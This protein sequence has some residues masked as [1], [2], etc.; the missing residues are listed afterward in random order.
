MGERSA[1]PDLVLE[2]ETGSTLMTP[3]H[4]YHVGR[5]PLSDI[6]IEDARVSWHH[7]VLR[8]GTDHWTL[9][10]ENSTNGTYADGRRVHE[11]DVGAGSVIHFG[12]PS[13]GPRAVLADRP[14]PAPERPSVVSAPAATGTFRR[15]TSVRPLPS[16]TVRIGRSGD[17]DL[18]VDD[19]GVSRR[20]AELR[21]LPDGTYEIVDL[22]S[23][24]G[25]FLNGQPVTRSRVGAGDIVGI[26]H[27]AFCLVGDQ[28]QEYVDTGEVS[29]DVQDLSVAVDR[30]RKTLLDRVSFPVG[31]KCLL[32]VVGPSGAGKSTLLNALTGQRPADRG[33]VLYDGRDLYRDYAELRRR[34]GLVPQED[35]LHAQLTVRRALTYAA[36]LRFPQDTAKAERRA[37]VDEVIRELGLE[38]RAGQPI[39]SLS[40]G[41]RKRVSV[42]LELLTKPSL[43]FLD[44]P[45]SGL[46][47]GMDRSV[48]HMLRGLADDGRTVVVVTHSVLSLDVCDR[49]LVLAPGGKVAYYGPP[50]ETLA[51]FG[52]EQWPEAFEAFERDRER[53]W[54]GD[55]R[56]S[57][58]HRQ[59]IVNSA[60]QPRLPRTDPAPGA[61]ARP[62]KAQSWGSQLGTLVR[63]YAA[64][65]GAD[66]TFLAIMIALPFVMGAM[67]RA[68]A[69]SRLTQETAMNALLILCVG[70]VLTGAANAVRELVKERVIYQRERA[71]GLS[72]SA[73][74]M[75]KVVVLGTVTVLQAV[76]L[77]LV[78]LLGVDLNAP[79]GEGV[80]LPPLVEITVA[81]ALLAFTAMMLGLL[82]SALVRKEEVTMPLLVLLAIVQVVF[83]G[84]LLKLDGV[85]GIEQ[86]SWLVPSRW[87]LGAM[88]GTIG[89]ARLVPGEL[90]ADPLFRHSAG[91]WLLNMGMLVVLSAL[92]GYVVA[93]LLRRHEP[94]VMRK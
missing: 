50:E 28:L 57:V 93:R 85:P 30:G 1:V 9:E 23:H 20:H 92:F 37:R 43:L 89:L 35:I 34:I 72:R 60:T 27:S 77:T 47:P 48:M 38:Q 58:Q 39:H 21:A 80:L 17:N 88:A 63:R 19:L 86:L 42:A 26:G 49:L 3:D 59:Y 71:V 70:G 52:Y 2:T 25:T 67:A 79:G 84:A 41:Q 46:D 29:L 4:E 53:D 94:A 33:T 32:A 74:L 56:A 12:A 65:L 83:C 44:E 45:T 8:P 81:V 13:D 66:R 69:G 61:F 6:V 78:A 55:Y 64:A 36:E 87:A 54:A 51:F 76:V 14:P 68:L 75:S 82:V 16:R 62:P 10:D 24:N 73:Y 7:A 40:G 18:V 5:D 31:E 91:V 22:G 11:W 90:T 15:P